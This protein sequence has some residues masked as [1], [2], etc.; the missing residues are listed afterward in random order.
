M[1]RHR[2]RPF[3]VPSPEP[4]EKPDEPVDKADEPRIGAEQPPMHADVTKRHCAPAIEPTNE[5]ANEQANEIGSATD[6][7]IR[8]AAAEAVGWGQWL[9]GTLD[10]KQRRAQGA[11]RRRHRRHRPPQPLVYQP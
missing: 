8:P 6:T 11:Q 7:P 4:V 3:R 10:E 2:V 5:Q 1:T 9:F